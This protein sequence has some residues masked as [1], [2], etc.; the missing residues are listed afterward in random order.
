[1][2]E[3]NFNNLGEIKGIQI[4]DHTGQQND[5]TGQKTSLAE[6]AAEIQALLKQLESTNPT[7][8]E[9][10][11]K[12]LVDKAAEEINKDHTLKE[13]VMSAVKS[14]SVESLKALVNNPLF[15]ILVATVEGWKGAD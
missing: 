13:R 11:K 3:I 15:N 9:T 4:G 14:G 5:F 1:M 12:A 7:T 2:S 8:T 10:E 6:V